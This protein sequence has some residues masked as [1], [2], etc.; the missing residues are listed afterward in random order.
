[1]ENTNGDTNTNLNYKKH[2]YDF[3]A[4]LRGNPKRWMVYQI[5]NAMIQGQNHFRIAPLCTSQWKTYRHIFNF[6]KPIP[7]TLDRNY[8]YYH[9][10]SNILIVDPLLRMM[11]DFAIELD[12]QW[13][14]A[15]SQVRDGFSKE[16]SGINAFIDY[17]KYR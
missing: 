11:I 7:A 9:K 4:Y 16:Y 12:L 14:P 13:Y 15:E 8:R 5:K 1:M 3:Y 10:Q 17:S 2:L 6:W